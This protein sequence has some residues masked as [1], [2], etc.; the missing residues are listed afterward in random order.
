MRTRQVGEQRGARTGEPQADAP[1]IVDVVLAFDEPALFE[2]IHEANHAV[3]F[4]LQPV[5][6]GPDHHRSLKA[7]RLHPEQDLMLLRGQ[8]GLFDG[9]AAEIQELADMEAEIGERRVVVVRQ[10]M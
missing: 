8:A 2:P 7:E 9:A 6:E 1:A 10:R 5:G 3:V 4:Q